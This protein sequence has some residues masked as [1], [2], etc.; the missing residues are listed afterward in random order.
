MY[1]VLKSIRIHVLDAVANFDIKHCNIHLNNYTAKLRIQSSID[2]YS[3]NRK[4]FHKNGF[5]DN[6]TYSMTICF[7]FKD[8]VVRNENFYT[9]H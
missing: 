4:V 7:Q 2:N 5:C 6:K 1:L 3:V 9:I 8:S